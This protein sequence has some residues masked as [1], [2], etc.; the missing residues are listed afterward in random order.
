MRK[1]WWWK[2]K[3]Y[4]SAL[5][6]MSACVGTLVIVY[7]GNVCK[8]SALE[9]E[10]TFYLGSASSQGLQAQ[11]LTLRDL[12]YV[13]GE[14]VAF[15]VEQGVG[16]EALAAEIAKKYDAEIVFTESVCGVTSY[17]ACSE[18]W[19]ESVTLYG[20]KINL[21]IAVSEEKCVVGCP[22]IFGGF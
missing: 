8:F 11:T 7:C 1:I 4:F 17:Y 12:P 13:K 18:R 22:I 16:K 21:H 6:A 5:L 20:K 2:L 10:R 15:S 3:T 9:G 19:Q 14:S